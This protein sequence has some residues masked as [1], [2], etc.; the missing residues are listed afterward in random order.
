MFLICVRVIPGLGGTIATQ[1]AAALRVPI[2]RQIYTMCAIAVP[3]C[4]ALAIGGDFLSNYFDSHVVEP[5]EAYAEKHHIRMPHVAACRTCSAAIPHLHAGSTGAAAMAVSVVDNRGSVDRTA[6]AR[7]ARRARIGI[8]TEFHNERSYT[9]AVDGRAAGVRRR[10]RD[11]RSAGA[12]RSA[13]AGGSAGAH[14]RS[15]GTRCR[16]ICASSPKTTASLPQA[17]FDTQ[18]AAAFCGYGSDDFAARSGARTRGRHAAQVANGQRLERASAQREADRLSRRRRAL[19]F[20][21]RRPAR[22]AARRTRPRGVGARRDAL[23]RRSARIPARRAAAVFARVGERAHVAARTGHSQRAGGVARRARARAQHSAQIRYARRRA[24]RT[25]VDCGRER[26]RI[27]ASCAGSTTGSNGTTVRA[28]S[29]RSHAAKRFR[30]AN[31][32]A[33]A[34]AVGRAARSARG[35][36]GGA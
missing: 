8:D 3:I 27:W 1:T 2:F 32:A 20:P 15:S 18:V 26:S 36:D 28:S 19:P 17:A 21:A 6:R 33:R 12:G 14:R 4:T 5:A 22:G 30:K 29:K 25:G 23:A 7:A 13:A 9:G 24:R 35:N 31:S 11:R 34:A 16:R 10:G